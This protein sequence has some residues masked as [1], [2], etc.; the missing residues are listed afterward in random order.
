[1]TLLRS[2]EE[3]EYCTYVSWYTQKI[4]TSDLYTQKFS[5]ENDVKLNQTQ[6]Q[7]KNLSV[8]S[9]DWTKWHY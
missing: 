2:V 3:I 5:R 9:E 1:M 8:L 4:Q 6:V 7:Y